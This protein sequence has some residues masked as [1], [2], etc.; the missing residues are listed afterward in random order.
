MSEP[1]R[2]LLVT[3]DDDIGDPLA[4]LLRSAGYRAAYRV[5]GADA[6]D[7]LQGSPPDALILDGDLSPA[8][9]RDIIALLDQRP[10]HASLPLLIL[11]GGD[12]CAP[13]RRWHED[14]VRMLRRPPDPGETVAT[15]AA[16]LRLAFYRPYRDLVHDLSQPVT[17]IHALAGMT[18]RATPPGSPQRDR[19]ERLGR[20]ADRLMTLLEEFQRKR[21]QSPG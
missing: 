9:W 12:A 16:L 15:L 6:V 4:A 18:L 8:H 19:V 14:A 5:G 10:S 13:P 17:S 20:E 11:G 1:P 7:E 2:I 3:D 21:M